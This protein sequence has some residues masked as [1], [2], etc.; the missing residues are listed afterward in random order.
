MMPFNP[1]VDLLTRSRRRFLQRLIT[2]GAWAVSSR[3]FFLAPL[4]ES[5]EARDINRQPG[6]VSSEFLYDT[7]SFP[8]C[9][10]STIVETTGGLVA[11]WFGGSDEGND[12][13]G[14][15]LARHDGARWSAPVEVANGIDTDGRRYPCWNPVLHAPGDGSLVLFYKVGP[16]PSRWWGLLKRSRDAGKSWE[17]FEHL[18][19]GVFGPIRNK[20]VRLPDGSLLCGSSTEH[21]GWQIQ[22]ERGTDNLRSWSKTGPLNDGS[23]LGL[24]QP[25][26]LTHPRG[27]LQILCRSRQQRIA[28]AWSEDQGRTWT[29]PVLTDL[30]N[31]NSGIDGVT[32]A[33]GGHLLVYNHTGRG[34]SPLNVAVSS[35]GKKWQGAL[36]L[37]E[38]RGEFSYP[39]VIQSQDRLIHIT[40]TW[41]RKRIRHVVIDPRKLEPRDIV[42]G[43]WPAT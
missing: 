43:K 36:V 39:A 27:R 18:P 14:I 13:V 22:M 19:L 31:P 16:S 21:D 26:I 35:D 25:T 5:S 15:W 4:G 28:E 37:E 10:A 1:P 33:D 30:P 7:A 38:E 29:A 42:D 6:W 20:P 23:K 32:L 17:A 41:N 34:R 9:H 12:D 8:S 40:Y 11:A 24:I 2:T 3:A